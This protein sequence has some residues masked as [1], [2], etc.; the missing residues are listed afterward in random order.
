M[1]RVSYLPYV[2]T[3]YVV[4]GLVRLHHRPG[5]IHVLLSKP[6]FYFSVQVV[7]LQI[8]SFLFPYL[9]GRLANP[10]EEVF[11]PAPR[12]VVVIHYARVDLNAKLVPIV[13]ARM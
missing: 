3:H 1:Y 7:Q 9:T 2:G 8:F 11:W 6:N 13:T 5:S 10:M 12:R 4:A